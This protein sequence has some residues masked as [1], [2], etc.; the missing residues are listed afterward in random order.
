[1]MFSPKITSTC[2]NSSPVPHGPFVWLDEAILPVE[3]PI[4]KQLRY[5]PVLSFYGWLVWQL[6]YQFPNLKLLGSPM[7]D[8]QGKFNLTGNT[9]PPQPKSRKTFCINTEHGCLLNMYDNVCILL[10]NVN[11]LGK[12]KCFISAAKWLEQDLKKSLR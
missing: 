3:Q 8:V 2:Q 11:V 5:E 1:M 10:S 9:F 7:V 12:N 6:S 4:K